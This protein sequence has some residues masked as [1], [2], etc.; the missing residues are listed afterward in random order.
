MEH[1]TETHA[2]H[3]SIGTF[4][5]VWLALVVLTAMLVIA[6]QVSHDLAVAAMLTLTP[7]KAGLVLYYFMHLKYEGVLL[8]AMV[9]VAIATLLV[10]IGFLFFDIGFTW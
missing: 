4:L 3:P 10:F 6:S 8:K 7:L 1:T 9:F 5:A 2:D